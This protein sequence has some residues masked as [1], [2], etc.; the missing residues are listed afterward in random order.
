MIGITKNDLLIGVSN[1]RCWHKTDYQISDSPK[2][3]KS[4][5]SPPQAGLLP[6]AISQP[7]HTPSRSATRA[8][9]APSSAR[10]TSN[11]SAKQLPLTPG[12]A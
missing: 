9:N 2:H 11:A 10:S 8:I 3:K 5:L 7:F 4:Q 6:S 1:V 12:A